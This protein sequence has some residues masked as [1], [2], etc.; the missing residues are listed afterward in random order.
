M[1][2]IIISPLS[3]HLLLLP[4]LPAF[5][6]GKNQQKTHLTR[7]FVVESQYYDSLRFYW[8]VMNMMYSYN[9]WPVNA[10][11]YDKS[12]ASCKVSTVRNNLIR[13][14]PNN[15]HTL[16]MF[17]IIDITYTQ[18]SS[19]KSMNNKYNNSVLALHRCI[20]IGLLSNPR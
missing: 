17:V 7:A 8:T 13:F 1:A 19:N 15:K 18:Q 14:Y 5:T 9:R 4:T 6:F 11:A 16:N 10:C 3:L 12:I 20:Y 2:L